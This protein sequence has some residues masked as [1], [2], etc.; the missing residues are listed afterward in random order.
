LNAFLDE[1]FLNKMHFSAGFA[2]SRLR[3]T[4]SLS[5]FGEAAALIVIW[6]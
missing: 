2:V 1:A 5:S 3:S 4:N 6:C